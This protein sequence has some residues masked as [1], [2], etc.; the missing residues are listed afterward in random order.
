MGVRWRGFELPRVLEC[1]KST[2]TPTYGKFM[3]EPFER[4]YGTTIGASL[5]RILISSIEGGAVT[6]VKIEGISHEFS[7]IPGVVEDV[8]QIVLNI[9]QLVLRA[10]TKGSKVIKIN[11]NKK[12]EVT[13][14]DIQTDGTVEV[15]NKDLHIAT[16]S[17]KAKFNIEMEVSK[18]RGYVPAE[19]NKREDQPIGVIAVDSIFSPVRKVNYRVENTRVGQATDYDKLILE[20]WTDASMSPEDAL[21]YGS[22]ILQ[23]HLEVFV[24]YSEFPEE[25]EEVEE[26]TGKEEIYE[27]LKRPISELELSVRSANCLKEARIKTIAD[28]VQKTET[29][30]LKYRNFGKK[31]L[32]EIGGILKGMSLSLGMKL[33]KGKL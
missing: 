21:V 3:A 14:K 2:L 10:H 17:K 8:T 12:G 16:L 6:S 24:N 18:G 13:A 7:T 22:N 11:V 4:G 23:R 29:Q 27:V 28:L 31:S 25:E 26:T 5:R 15:L 32:G 9:K 30:M 19:R 33:E 20:I 1:D